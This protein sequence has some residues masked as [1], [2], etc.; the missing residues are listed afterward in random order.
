VKIRPGFVQAIVI[1]VAVVGCGGTALAGAK[2]AQA[3]KV[4][5]MLMALHSDYVASGAQVS[6]V[7]FTRPNSRM[8]IADNRVSID[9]VADEDASVLAA[10]LMALGM[11]SVAV[12]GR[13]VSGQLP[14]AAIPAL[15]RLGSLRF[16][17]PSIAVRHVGSVTSQGD[18]AMR[19]D[20]VR[21]ASG[22]SG[23]G[24]KI[25]VLS[26]SFNCKGGA[27]ANVATGDLPVVQ[28]IQE[29]PDCTEATDEGRA[30]LQIVHDI[31]PA[32]SLAFATTD[33][34]RAA[35]AN[36]I[37]ALRANGAQ[38]IVDDVVF[39]A[40]SM[41][42]DGIVAQAVDTVVRQGATYLSAA[43]N[44]AR[45]SYEAPF[46]PG[47]T[48]AQGAFPSSDRLVPFFGGT[49]HNFAPAGQPVD[50]FQRITIPAGAM[51]QLALQWDSPSASAGGAGSP[52][53]VDVYLFNA[54]RTQVVTGSID[55][56]IGGDPARS[57]NS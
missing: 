19:A 42:Q 53:D 39:L 44:A 30:M 49:A 50:H 26:D 41:F 25:G 32:A 11:R 18:R 54:A 43:G 13:V 15:E 4:S 7:P 51:L 8:R 22:V 23:A 55:P 33:P 56:N 10:D 14:V 40:E 36:N 37:L 47:M 16:V 27:A 28:V 48:F 12:H 52:N 35:F 46:K 21:A 38:V 34:G 5:S 1:V 9:A 6:G 3:R 24:V 20:V 45:D 31:A 2:D 29:E 57:S 17:R